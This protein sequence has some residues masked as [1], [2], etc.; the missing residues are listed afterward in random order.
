MKHNNSL[1]PT[2]PINYLDKFLTDSSDFIITQKVIKKSRINTS[3]S[4]NTS[5]KFIEF[6]KK[7]HNG[8]LKGPYSLEL[9]R[10]ILLYL[11]LFDV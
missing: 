10:A 5:K 1:L 11:H 3:I 4:D 6:V 8:V 7:N 2:Y 9:E